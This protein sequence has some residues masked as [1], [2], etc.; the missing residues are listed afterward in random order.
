[1][2]LGRWHRA[3]D[4]AR[5]ATP[6]A[7]RVVNDT[8]T[9]RIERVSQAPARAVFDAWTREEVVRR[10][11]HA[12]HDWVTTEA[13]VDLRVVGA[14]RVVTRNPHTDI[15]YGGGG[16]YT[17]IDPPRRLACTWL[18]DGNDKRQLIEID[19]HQV[20]GVTTV[21]FTHRDLWDEEAVRSHEDGWRNCFDNLERVL[22]EDLAAG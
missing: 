22:A 7:A 11:W 3:A 15:E 6:P 5:R 2:P 20:D 8:A 1:L 9:L 21:R 12:A 17:E 4:N 16:R 14:L 19:L 18:W 13:S 10:W